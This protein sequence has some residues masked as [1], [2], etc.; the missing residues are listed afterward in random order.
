M[1]VSDDALLVYFICP[2]CKTSFSNHI[3]YEKKTGLFSLLIKNHPDGD[4]CAPFIAYIDANGR[5]RGSQ[6]IDNIEGDFSENEQFLGSA[7]EKINE[8]DK[9]IKF[10]HIK[11]PRKKGRGFEHKV[12]SVMAR[13]FMSSKF[14]TKLIDYLIE[15]DAVNTFGTITIEADS[16]FE[17]G[18]LIYGKY[19]EMAFTIFWK[20][21]KSLPNKTI[22]ELKAFALLTIEKLLDLYDLMD[23][24]F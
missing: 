24:F 10:Y 1:T 9:T 5:H 11:V 3:D 6:K 19:L 8:L 15:N 20:D 4:S 12:A 16:G 18:V 17:E 23:Y 14:Y 22:E 2:Y 21:Q 13:S 7:Q